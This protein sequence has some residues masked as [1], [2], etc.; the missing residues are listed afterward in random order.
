MG[1]LR[2]RDTGERFVFVSTHLARNPESLKQQGL[3]LRQVAQ[4]MRELHT[5]YKERGIDLRV[6]QPARRVHSGE[7]PA[8]PRHRADVASMA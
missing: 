3:R 7:E 2:R 4:L 5:F 1:V 6:N 8:S